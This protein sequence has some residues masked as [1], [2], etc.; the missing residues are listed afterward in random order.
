MLIFYRLKRERGGLNTNFNLSFDELNEDIYSAE[1]PEASDSDSDK[2]FYI[3]SNE[4]IEE[5][6]S[7]LNE[8]V[9]SRK[10]IIF[11]Y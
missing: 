7:Y 10:V 4:T 8:E 11:S 9:V 5:Y 3:S 6:S 1:S 2:E